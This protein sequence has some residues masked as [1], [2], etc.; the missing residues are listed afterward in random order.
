MKA[1]INVSDNDNIILATRDP[2]DYSIAVHGFIDWKA[3]TKFL[4]RLEQCYFYW[5]NYNDYTDI[6]TAIE[7]V[8][9]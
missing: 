7:K 9:L 6:K 2:N 8:K 4:G 3:M 1:Y 5:C